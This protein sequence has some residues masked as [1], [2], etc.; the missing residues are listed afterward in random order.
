MSTPKKLN[1]LIKI[2]NL[3]IVDIWRESGVSPRTIHHWMSNDT[4]TPN[5]EKFQKVWGVAVEM[6]RLRRDEAL[7]I[8]ARLAELGVDLGATE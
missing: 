6:A 2:A 1:S 5:P 8:D 4:Q 3:K 7:S